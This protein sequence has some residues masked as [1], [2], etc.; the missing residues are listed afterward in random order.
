[1]PTNWNDDLENRFNRTRPREISTPKM[2]NER[3]L[4][5]GRRGDGAILRLQEVFFPL[6]SVE[7]IVDEPGDGGIWYSDEEVAGFGGLMGDSSP[8][9]PLTAWSRALYHLSKTL[10][11]NESVWLVEDD[12]AGNQSYFRALVTE[13][14]AS[15]PDLAAFEIRSKEEDQSWYHW[16]D[17]DFGFEQPWRA[18]A[19]LCR[20]SR[21]LIQAILEYRRKNHKFVFHEVLFASLVIQHGMRW[22]DWDRETGFQ[23][24]LGAYRYRPV[25]DTVQQGINHPVKDAVIHAEICALG[26]APSPLNS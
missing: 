15:D 20:M 4:I 10:A 12:V 13:T 23:R 8:L 19:P 5:L 21:H 16:K 6:G 7:V 3:F 22:L 26:A 25:V 11:E 2:T 1:M 17:G 18:F 14:A 24:L 9:P